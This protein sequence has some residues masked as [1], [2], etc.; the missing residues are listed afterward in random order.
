MPDESIS[1]Y[2]QRLFLIFAPG[3][4]RKLNTSQDMHESKHLS[5]PPG[6]LTNGGPPTRLR[7]CAKLAGAAQSIFLQDSWQGN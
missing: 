2:T 3:A 4:I 5:K 1:S 7:V 6:A